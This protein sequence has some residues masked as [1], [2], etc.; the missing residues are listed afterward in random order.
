MASDVR[1][2]C[3]EL[4]TWQFVA[5]AVLLPYLFGV[6]AL[7]AAAAALSNRRREQRRRGEQLDRR[8]TQWKKFRAVVGVLLDGYRSDVRIAQFW[9]AF[10]LLRRVALGLLSLFVDWPTVTVL[11]NLGALVATLMIKPFRDKTEYLLEVFSLTALLCNFV[12]FNWAHAAEANAAHQVLDSL[13]LIVPTAVLML[14]CVSKPLRK[15]A[16]LVFSLRKRS[17]D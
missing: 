8:G 12:H 2:R 4:G 6:V 13:L 17:I 10:V 3:S 16:K 7:V 1:V 15:I 5:K 14:A 11:I 9:D